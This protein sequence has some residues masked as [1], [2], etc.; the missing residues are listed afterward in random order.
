MPSILTDIQGHI[1][2]I[3]LNRPQVRNAW[4][5]ELSLELRQALQDFNANEQ[6]RACVVTATGNFFSAGLDLKDPPKNEAPMAMPNLS[7]TCDK[8]IL[9]AVEGGAIGY[10][11]VFCQLSDMVFAGEN[12]Y[13]LYPE[14]KMGL[15]QGLMGGFP[16]RLQYK[17]A[18]QWLMTGEPI[19]AE[20]A[21]EIGLVNEVVPDGQA[22]AR[23]M[24][25][26]ARISANA[27]LVIRAMK[28]IALA[29]VTKGPMEENF[30]IH[31]MLDDIAHSED[32]QEGIASFREKRSAHF[33]G[34]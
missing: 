15:F 13:F 14:A 30:R 21:R 22:L 28:A 23:A 34:R 11:S 1:Q 26:A 4:N 25:V 32:G 7:I 20:R 18:L 9:V 27:P 3:T 8:P 2:V 29:T 6:L 31:R 24:A 12:A 10:A 33:N 16:G 17:G 5:P 19:S